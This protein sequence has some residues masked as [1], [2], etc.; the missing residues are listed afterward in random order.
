V[1]R[2]LPVPSQN[3]EA[4]QAGGEVLALGFVLLLS[5]IL[6]AMNAW[7]VIDAKIR[8]AGAARFS[9]RTLV[10]SQPGEISASLGT[11][12]FEGGDDNMAIKAVKLALTDRPKLLQNIRVVVALPQGAVRCARV[13]VSVRATVPA[14][15]FPRVGP[16][17][18]GFEVVTS[19][20]EIIDPFRS[21][22]EGSGEC[23]A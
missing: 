20:S 17:R 3:V 4:G 8:V 22:L 5:M 13:I 2:S 23:R 11:S 15:G 18:H 9:V 12:G 1:R 19:Q 14:F 16:L 7:A 10:E 6:L 21:G